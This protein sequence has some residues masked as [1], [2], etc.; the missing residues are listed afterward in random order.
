MRLLVL[1]CAAALLCAA[2]TYVRVAQGNPRYLELATGE[3]FIPI[4]PNIAWE[5]Y[6]TAEEEIF[7]RTEERFRKLAANGGNFSRVWISHP[8]YD[9]DPAAAPEAAAQ[10]LGRIDRLLELAVRYKLRLKL[11]IE[12]FR[13]LE[14]SPPVFPGSVSMGRPEYAG[15]FRDMT[16]YF[17]SPV[18][19]GVYLKKL[20]M[21]AARYRGHPAV[22]GWELW[23][24]INAV[25]GTGW[26]EWTAAMLPELKR[27]FPRHFALQSLGSFDR[28]AQFEL[29]QRFSSMPGN[30]IAQVH[31]YLDP[32]A[33]LDVCR[34][35]MDTLAADAVARLLAYAPDRPVILSEVGA[36][37]ANHAGPSKL[38]EKDR[39]GTLLH[40]ALFAGFFAGGAGP[41]QFWHWQDYI[42]KHDL[43]H[44]FARFAEAVRGIDPRAE[45]FEP[46]RLEH[47]KLR[48]YALVGKRTMLLWL[49]DA[50]SDWRTEI[51]QGRPAAMLQGLKLDVSSLGARA[52]IRFY[53]PWA[54]RWAKGRANGGTVRLP[55]FRRSLVARLRGLT[56]DLPPLGASASIRF[57]DPRAN[58]RVK[59]CA[60]GGTVRLPLFRQSQVVWVEGGKVQ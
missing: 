28:D 53:D 35:P 44:H 20:D 45:R 5:R 19:R 39:E 58:C 24:E 25:R 46:R 10:K 56:L 33:R 29:Y 47:P 54:N 59:G 11:C 36:V 38:Y 23:N 43:W 34:G 12:H 26:E 4:G 57:H 51:E 60:N 41:G 27:R 8:F 7:A 1:L 49:R 55:P 22:F 48:V 50:A 31:R 9:V 15:L 18:G 52:S 17:S 21:L 32:G 37:E 14:A 3:V 16:Q 13:T 42:E 2:Q 30:E 6:A 40:D